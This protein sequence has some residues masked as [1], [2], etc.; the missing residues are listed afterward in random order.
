LA[1]IVVLLFLHRIYLWVAR[2]PAFFKNKKSQANTQKGINAV[3]RGLT[4]VASGDSDTSQKMAREARRY[5]PQE[6]GLTLLLEAQSARLKGDEAK[7]NECFQALLEDKNAAFLG[8]RGLLS[9]AL[10]EKD[11]PK[12][13]DYA[14]KGL[15]M[16]PRQPWI[17][18]TGLG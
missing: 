6:K 1:F 7:A 11:Y 9:N 8:V 18:R 13:L 14:R 10:A 3:T 4:A 16:N 5:L 2:L 12:A 17:I 15:D